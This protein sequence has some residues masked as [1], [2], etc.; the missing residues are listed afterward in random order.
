MP[1]LMKQETNY[2]ELT[3]ELEPALRYLAAHPEAKVAAVADKFKKPAVKLWAWLGRYNRSRP[4][5]PAHIIDSALAEPAKP[6]ASVATMVSRAGGKTSAAAA[7]IPR[8]IAAPGANM[9]EWLAK[10][11]IEVLARPQCHQV[12]VS[13]ELAAAWLTLNS[14][15]RKPSKAKI[16]RFAAAIKAGRW[17]LNGETIKFSASGRLLDGQS[18]LQAIVLAGAPA[19]LELRG[20]LP[21]EAQ[22]SMDIGEA[23]KG[24]HMLEMLGEKYPTIVAP[25]LKLIFRWENGSIGSNGTG[26]RRL[27]ENLL[28]ENA[29]IE[30]TLKRHAGLRASVG[31]IVS[32]GYKVATLMPPSE[33]A[34]FHYLCGLASAKKRD[35]FFTA[36]ATGLGLT[37]TSPAYHLRERLQANRASAAKISPRERYALIIKAWNA[38]LAGDKLNQLGFRATGDNREAFPQVAGVKPP[39]KQAA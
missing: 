20:G 29:D 38:H 26:N 4:K 36:L 28:L 17:A 9:E 8:R 34:F 14:G 33:G 37:A 11:G 18:R 30:P 35:E 22:K 19:R 39:R 3:R 16:R 32:A 24:A 25:A 27:G 5:L 10:Q 23:R 12:L 7:P 13:P 1:S 21:D 6:A 15:N 2:H 31:W